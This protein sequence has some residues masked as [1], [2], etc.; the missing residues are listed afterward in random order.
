[1]DSYEDNLAP[2]AEPEW[3]HAT[4]RFPG[5]AGVSPEAAAKL[6]A[7]LTGTGRRFH[8]LRKEA[9][10]RLRTDRPVNALL[11]QLVA[12]EVAAG[13]T[14]GIYEAE[15]DAFGGPQGMVIAGAVLCRQPRRAGRDRQP[16]QQR[17][18]HPAAVLDV[19]GS[20][21]GPVRSR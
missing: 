21:A 8:F 18:V 7:A 5:D 11:D 14:A 19:L 12:D 16:Q 13:W 15:T 1:M 6:S 17:T 4:I 10:L 9:G 3:W 2:P 20:R